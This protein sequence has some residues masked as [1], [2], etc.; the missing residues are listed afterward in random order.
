MMSLFFFWIRSLFNGVFVLTTDDATTDFCRK[1]GADSRGALPC[2]R[3]F[4]KLFSLVFLLFYYCFQLLFCNNR[5]ICVFSLFLA[6]LGLNTFF[7]LLELNCGPWNATIWSRD[8]YNIVD[9]FLQ[10]VFHCLN[11]CINSNFFNLSKRQRYRLYY[12]ILVRKY[13]SLPDCFSLSLLCWYFSRYFRFRFVVFANRTERKR[14]ILRDA[15]A[16]LLSSCFF[17]LKAA[18]FIHCL[19]LYFFAVLYL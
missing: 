13:L 11:Y 1:E 10:F 5:C 12:V 9:T 15:V 16:S 18:I 2:I 6:I 14:K 19:Y 8:V 4:F 3:V 17:V 7:Y